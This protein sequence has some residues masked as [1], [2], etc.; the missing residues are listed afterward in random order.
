MNANSRRLMQALVN[1]HLLRL[2][3]DIKRG[4]LTQEGR[5]RYQ[6]MVAEAQR[7]RDELE[8]EALCE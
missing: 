5:D 1:E 7:A 4:D 3:R 6:R 8:R 2:L